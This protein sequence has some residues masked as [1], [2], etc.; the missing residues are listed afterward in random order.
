MKRLDGKTQRIET[1]TYREE[2]DASIIRPSKYF[3]VGAKLLQMSDGRGNSPLWGFGNA[4]LRLLSAFYG[5]ELKS[6][7]KVVSFA[8][9]E[10]SGC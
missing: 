2:L 6:A 5:G 4:I 10:A 8:S 3:F 1:F 9:R 7:H